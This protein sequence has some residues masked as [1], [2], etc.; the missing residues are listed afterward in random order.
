MKKR[1]FRPI[2][3]MPV[4]LVF[5]VSLSLTGASYAFAPPT[6]TVC[7]EYSFSNVKESPL[8]TK[9]S[10]TAAGSSYTYSSIQLNPP[11]GQKPQLG[12]CT[13]QMIGANL[14]LNCYV[15]GDDTP[16]EPYRLSGNGQVTLNCSNPK[17]VTGNW[18][19][20]IIV[21]DTKTSEITGEYGYGVVS[22]IPCPK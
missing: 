19:L 10:I 20:N 8:I 16:A 6:G 2:G 5:A 3:I 9:A 14:T 11:S 21:A 1:N 15:S 13:G 22:V 4:L 7:L 12:S 17:K 18:W